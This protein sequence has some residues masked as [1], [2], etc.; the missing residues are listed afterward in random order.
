MLRMKLEIIMGK[1]GE[2]AMKKALGVLLVGCLLAALPFAF[3]ACGGDGGGGGATTEGQLPTFETGDIWTW[4]YTV[5]GMDSVLTEEVIGEEEM[6]GRDCYVLDMSFEPP[7]TFAEAE[8][9]STITGMTYWGD[10]AT[11]F[12]EVKRDMMGS[13]NGTDFTLSLVSSYSSWESLFP[14]EVGKEVETE[15]TMTQYYD[16][17]QSGGPAVTAERFV[18]ESRETLTVSA[19]TFDCFKIVIYDGE[20]A[21]LQIVWWSDEAKSMARSDDG[22]GNTLMEMLSYSVS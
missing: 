14:L 19:G 5:Q 8:G 11:A 13:Y 6:E 2:N 7:L 17:T 20:G 9:E 18:V 3:V 21:I 12:Y 10:K 16:G 22:D 1:K 15:Q 4:H